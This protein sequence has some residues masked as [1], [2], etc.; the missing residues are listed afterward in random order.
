MGGYIAQSCLNLFTGTLEK[1]ET[2]VSK[3]YL[4]TFY[5][6]APVKSFTVFGE[7]N[8][9]LNL[10]RKLIFGGAAQWISAQVGNCKIVNSRFGS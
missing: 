10:R 5:F 3:E 8:G 7:T 1:C 2:C 4:K 6:K 9:K